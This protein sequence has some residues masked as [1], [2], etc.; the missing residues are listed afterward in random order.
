M[1]NIQP[2]QSFIKQNALFNQEERV[3]LAV[4]GG[5][6][7]VLM[8]HY[9]K[10]SEYAFGIAHCNFNLRGTDS[11]LEEEFTLKLAKKM[12]VSFFSTPFPT[13]AYA[14]KNRIS[15]QM[16]AREMRYQWLEEI[17]AKF[18]YQYIALAHHQ[19]DLIET[20][21]LNLTRG[22]G[23]AGLHG[24]LPKRNRIIRPL[25]FLSRTEINQ[26]TKNENFDYCNDA[27]NSLS[28]YARNKIR[29]QVIPVLKELNPKLEFT[30]AENIRR[31]SEVEI[32][33]QQRVAF[34]R[35]NLFCQVSEGEWTVSIK[36]IQELH[37]VNIL[38]YELLNPYG[39]TEAV[40]HDLKRNLGNQPG[41][42]FE[43]VSHVILIDR[44]NL[45]LSVKT[46]TE[47]EQKMIFETDNYFTWNGDDYECSLLTALDFKI[48]PG[49]NFVQL[50]SELL[51]FPIKM[52]NWQSGDFFYP[53]GMKGRK[54][55]SDYFIEQKIPLIHK[56]KIGVLQNGNGDILW[57]AGYR[58]DERYKITAKTEKIFTLEKVNSNGK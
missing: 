18:G 40:I 6:D 26:I 5:R 25:L 46:K 31:F 44:G 22:T 48:K 45:I 16:A 23:I 17:R 10:Q 13:T 28:K 42:R 56:E 33:L 53:L 51:N 55:L 4:S 21:L 34:L 2:F 29:L 54:K 36:K 9:F 32:I 15:I 38:L 43:S 39:F 35:K 14:L 12:D 57:I 47:I 3:L 11:D 24:I 49:N 8:A 27:S 58:A 52:R 7:S 20:V 19:N 30:F 41:K 1:L 50:N 37:P